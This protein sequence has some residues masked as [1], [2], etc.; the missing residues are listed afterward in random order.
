MLICL[1]K[2][3]Q[4]RSFQLSLGEANAREEIIVQSL[5]IFGRYMLLE[6]DRRL[7]EMIAYLSIL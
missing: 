7:H 3:R 1:F 4:D 6:N 2:R 5:S